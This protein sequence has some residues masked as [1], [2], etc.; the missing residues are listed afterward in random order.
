MRLQGFLIRVGS[1]ALGGMV[2]AGCLPAAAQNVTTTPETGVTPNTPLL[3]R[4]DFLPGKEEAY[5]Q[6]AA[7]SV[8]GYAGAKHPIYWRALQPVTGPP[9]V[10]SFDGFANFGDLDK[11]GADLAQ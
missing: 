11:A 6:T 4:A 2:V 5:Q 9:Q 8:Q 3:Y 1:L 10:M 7:D